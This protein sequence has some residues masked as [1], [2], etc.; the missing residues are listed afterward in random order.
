MN[1]ASIERVSRAL[2]ELPGPAGLPDHHAFERLAAMV[3]HSWLGERTV[4]RPCAAPARR[5]TRSM[6]S[7]AT[8]AS[9]R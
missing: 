1:V 8:T 6:C 7:S 2:A 5:H 4:Q 3:V 9:A